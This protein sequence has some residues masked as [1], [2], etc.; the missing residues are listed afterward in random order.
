MDFLKNPTPTIEV[1]VDSVDALGGKLVRRLKGLMHTAEMNS[2]G[3]MKVKMVLNEESAERFPPKWPNQM[4]FAGVPYRALYGKSD[5]PIA[6]V[7]T[8]TYRDLAE[9]DRVGLRPNLD[10]SDLG[11]D[12]FHNC[13]ALIRIECGEGRVL[14]G[15]YRF[16]GHR[17]YGTYYVN[18]Q[19]MGKVRVRMSKTYSDGRIDIVD[20]SH[21]CAKVKMDHSHAYDYPMIRMWRDERAYTKDE[22]NEVV[23]K[24]NA[25]GDGAYVRV[26]EVPR[27]I[28][29]NWRRLYTVSMRAHCAIVGSR[30]HV[31]A[32]H[33]LH[34]MNEQLRQGR[35]GTVHGLQLKR[36]P[37]NIHDP[38]AVAVWTRF[39]LNGETKDVHLGY[40]PRQDA[41]V[42]AKVMDAGVQVRATYKGGGAFEAWWPASTKEGVDEAY[43]RA[44]LE[45]EGV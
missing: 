6:V 45:T 10:C 28:A 19:D 22:L 16:V 31:G 32:D 38:N 3:S 8:V 29:P 41:K 37:D 1:F 30:Y 15:Q 36:E 42:I 40:V 35:P 27:G 9:I 14:P 4:N 39:R 20:Q 44:M 24:A 13:M 23:A 11:V 7:G 34:K 2:D 25:R 17:H 18:P 33:C 21:P 5:D 12:Y 43:R 26:E